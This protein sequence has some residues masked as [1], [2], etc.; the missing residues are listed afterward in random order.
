MLSGLNNINKLTTEASEA[1]Q[2]EDLPAEWVEEKE[3]KG[4]WK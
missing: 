1:D 2:Q 4:D 3:R